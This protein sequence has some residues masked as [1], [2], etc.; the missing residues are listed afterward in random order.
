MLSRQE[1]RRLKADNESRFRDSIDRNIAEAR[2][3]RPPFIRQMFI[4]HRSQRTEH[5]RAIERYVASLKDEHYTIVAF[6]DSRHPP[7]GEAGAEPGDPILGM[8]RGLAV[9][10]RGEHRFGTRY[11]RIVA[12]SSE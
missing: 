11:V 9:L 6:L 7:V 12:R 4:V 3:D 8:R 1:R 10:R 2:L 5:M